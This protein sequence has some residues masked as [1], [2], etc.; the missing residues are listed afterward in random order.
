MNRPE[1]NEERKT[2]LGELL[3]V[4]KRD[5]SHD[6]YAL[7]GEPLLDEFIIRKVAGELSSK[8]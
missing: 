4:L 3:H 5:F 8:H 1:E 2:F 6:R 7:V